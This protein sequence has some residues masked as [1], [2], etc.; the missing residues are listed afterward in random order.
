MNGEISANYSGMK[1]DAMEIKTAGEGYKSDV[2]D[3][4]RIVDNLSN[5]WKGSDNIAYVN[6]ANSY[7]DDLKKLGDVV[8]SYGDFLI[9]S[10]NIISN[11]QDEV[12]SNA[13][14]L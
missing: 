5:N 11:I 4:F 9:K 3:L 1:T 14:K 12:S 13:G 6:T 2:N 10:A 7:K 8:I